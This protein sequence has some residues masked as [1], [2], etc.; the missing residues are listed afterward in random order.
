MGTAH[1]RAISACGQ[2]G[3]RAAVVDPAPSV[4]VRHATGGAEVFAALGDVDLAAFDFAVVAAPSSQHLRISHALAGHH[5]A[6]LLEKPCGLD[7]SQYQSLAALSTVARCRFRVGFWRRLCEPFRTLKDILTSGEIGTPRMVLACQWD[8]FIPALATQPVDDTGGIG[9]D[10]GIHETDTIAWL[11]LGSIDRLTM[12]APTPHCSRVAAGDHD[13]LC[14]VA[15][16]DRGVAASISLSRTAGG[17][18]EI[19]YKVI[20]DAGSIE[21]RLGDSATI[22]IH[23]AG[24]VRELPALETDCIADALRQQVLAA[25]GSAAGDGCATIDDVTAAAAPWLELR[26]TS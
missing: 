20:G 2:F 1:A 4:R 17:I 18:D 10:C 5:L 19:F 3:A 12:V 6:V 7:R 13:Q 24:A 11:G 15:V 26:V 16:T 23:R 14:A 9:L 22:Q 8:A 21:L 25:S